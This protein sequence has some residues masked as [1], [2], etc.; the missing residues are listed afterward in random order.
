MT[1]SLLPGKWNWVKVIV[2]PAKP[3]EIRNLEVSFQSSII[4]FEMMP[5]P[6]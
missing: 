4:S 1:D 2:A 5:K 6:Q 3:D